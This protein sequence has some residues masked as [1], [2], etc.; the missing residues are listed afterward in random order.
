MIETDT[1]YAVRTWSPS[2]ST[3]A[4]NREL[5]NSTCPDANINLPKLLG[6]GP[7]LFGLFSATR[8]T[9]LCGFG[10]YVATYPI[11]VSFNFV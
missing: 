8:Q 11:I 1:L 7:K 4:C 5:T 6:T 3:A 2:L 10:W 9:Q